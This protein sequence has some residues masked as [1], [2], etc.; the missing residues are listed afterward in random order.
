MNV[1]YLCPF[2]RSEINPNQNIILSTKT[3]HNHVGLVLLHE[4]MGNYSVIVSP[5]L[6]I[7]MGEVVEFFC[8]VCHESLN[9][10]KGEHFATYIRVDDKNKESNIIISRKHGEECTYKIDETKKVESYGEYAK[11]YRN[12]EWFLF[13]E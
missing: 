13:K 12:P 4:E 7:E 11:K 8:P 5:S 10:E 9:T 1:K 2:C 3:K 6:K